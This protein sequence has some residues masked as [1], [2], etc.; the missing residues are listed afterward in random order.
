MPFSDMCSAHTAAVS[1]PPALAV[2]CMAWLSSSAVADGIAAN[3]LVVTDRHHPV[4]LAPDV[5]HIRVIELDLP[6]RIEA[7]LTSPLSNNPDQAAAHL[8]ERLREGGDPLQQ[9][10]REA[11]QGVIDAWQLGVT[12]IPA[13]VVERRHVV[14]GEPDVARALERITAH[15]NTRR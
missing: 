10:L 7:Q 11:Y 5:R 13:V 6:A 8:R 4:Q 15:R 12:R 2:L 1:W 3:I 14:Y 9:H